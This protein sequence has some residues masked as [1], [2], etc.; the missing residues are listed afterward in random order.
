MLKWLIMVAI[1]SVCVTNLG[2]VEWQE[3]YESRKQESIQYREAVLSRR[4]AEQ[5]LSTQAGSLVPYFDVGLESENEEAIRLIDGELQPLSVVPTLRFE[6]LF[7]GD[8]TLSVPIGVYETEEPIT[9]IDLTVRSQLLA[10]IDVELLLSQAAILHAQVDEYRQELAVRLQLMEDVLQARYHLQGQA[11]HNQNLAVLERLLSEAESLEDEREVRRQ[12]LKAQRGSMQAE[13]GLQ[14]IDAVIRNN[15]EELYAQVML[16]ANQWLRNVRMDGVVPAHSRRI[17]AREYEL[18][19]AQLRRRRWLLPY[20]PNPVVSGGVVYDVLEGDVSWNVSLQFTVGVFDRGERRLTAFRRREESEI[21]KLRL[22]QEE[23]NLRDAVRKARN[24]LQI[25]ELNRRLQEIDLE[26]AVD[27]ERAVRE[28]YDAGLA[29]DESLVIA[30]IDV[31]VE[32]LAAMQMEHDFLMQRLR[33]L[34]YYER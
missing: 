12:I 22:H 7:G 28:L 17:R 14:E 24:Q 21:Y 9:T 32:Q 23:R 33:M 31:S 19:A 4:I 5:G 6:G 3:L 13:Y 11:I 29:T 27:E 34:E 10:E 2:A 26:D 15:N 20:L 16:L 8:V 18:A 30:E 25:A 1:G